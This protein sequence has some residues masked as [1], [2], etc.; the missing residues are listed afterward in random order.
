MSSQKGKTHN[1]PSSRKPYE[2]SRSG[3][4]GRPSTKK[5][6][7]APKKETYFDL[8]RKKQ[9]GESGQSPV[10]NNI[11]SE[12][13]ISV[14]L[15][16]ASQKN[17]SDRMS[18]CC[19]SNNKASVNVDNQGTSRNHCTA[20]TSTN[21]LIEESPNDFM[22]LETAANEEEL[23]FNID[24]KFNS[25]DD[26]EVT[27]KGLIYAIN[28]SLNTLERRVDDKEL[29]FEDEMQDNE[30]EQELDEDEQELDEDELELDE[31]EKELDEDEQELDED[32]KE[33]D[34]DELELDEDEQDLDE[35]KE[36]L[37]EVDQELDEENEQELDE[38]DQELDEENE[39]ELDEDEQELD[40]DKQELDEDERDLDEDEQEL[41]EDEK[42]LDDEVEQ[43][44]QNILEVV[45]K[46]KKEAVKGLKKSHEESQPTYK[47]ASFIQMQQDFSWL[48][49]DGVN[50]G[51]K[52]KMC[53][54][55]PEGVAF[56][57]G[58]NKFKFSHEA[59]KDLSGHPMRK[60]KVHEDSKKHKYALRQYENFRTRQSLETLENNKEAKDVREAKL[61]KIAVEKL[62][63]ITVYMV[64]KNW[65]HVQNYN[66]FV[67]FIGRDL[68]ESV[69]SEYLKMASSH[70]NAT[71]LSNFTVRKFVKLIGEYIEKKT[72]EK[73]K[74]CKNFTI[75]LDESTDDANRS[76]LALIARI[77]DEKGV[78]QNHFL[79]LIQLQRCDALSIFTAVYDYLKKNEID[80][81]RICFSG[82]DGCSTMMGEHKGVAQHFKNHCSHHSSIHC[83]NHRLALC[84]SHLIPWY[85]PFKN[86][87]GLLLNLFLMLKHSSVKT[88]LFNEIQQ[89][90]DL[91]SLK[92]IKAATTRWLSHG[93]ASQRVLDRFEPLITTLIAIYE[94][95]K[96]PAVQGL[97]D[98][99]TEPETIA[100]LCFLSDVMQCTNSFQV[101]LQ[102]SRLNFLD[103][104]G[105]AKELTDKL[106]LIK[107]NPCRPNSNFE[108]LDVFL[109]VASK[110]ERLIN[111][112][113][114]SVSRSS[115]SKEKYTNDVIKPFISDLIQEIEQS[116]EIPSHLK[117]FSV[118]D[119]R[120][121]PNN[122][123]ELK[124]Y[125][126]DSIVLL[127]NFYGV[128]SNI[129]TGHFHSKIINHES[130]QIQFKVFKNFAFV[131]KFEYE[132][133]QRKNLE[134][135]L[136]EK[137]NLENKL[138]SL[139][140]LL[141]SRKQ[142]II[143]QQIKT[144]DKKIA[145]LR[146]TQKMSFEIMLKRWYEKNFQEKHHDISKMLEFAALIPPST[147]EV[148]RAFSLMKLIC[149]RLRRSL[150]QV[151][152]AHCMRI[153]K[154]ELTKDDFLQI[155]D[156]W[157]GAEDT[158]SKKRKISSRL[159]KNMK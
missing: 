50:N 19:F 157:L 64:K 128:S 159:S 144:L 23:L 18:E 30:D 2:R 84:F 83:R 10:T 13:N 4:G 43:D 129:G 14:S 3:I 8:L 32:E 40:E 42:E 46:D 140:D 72:I 5:N 20:S 86:F 38:V 127:S 96:E 98:E 66:D 117:G 109:E 101:F 36:D 48:Y 52:C 121:L 146:K 56:S 12:E 1:Y 147:S 103:L 123:E 7:S 45:E 97:L 112:R 81:T 107:T 77:V 102:H 68:E 69:L 125:G 67:T 24:D 87:D 145:E 116:F 114:R 53:E 138:M 9:S 73:I 132:N 22:N 65:A 60:L 115:F 49:Y 149:T 76:E 17:Q 71:Y 106:D 74:K 63:R 142:T 16:S 55:F 82:M 124:D 57:N 133:K 75:L 136:R 143:K 79:T 27:K 21:S 25:K 85:K 93:K 15:L 91:E 59:V 156:K 92:L 80:I 151:N 155:I 11:E 90:Y 34:E 122:R 118:L 105:K 28:T 26:F 78:V 104:P 89:S 137:T 153:S 94:R 154:Y 99:L 130:L 152:L 134:D 126:N 141:T 111:T 110:Q 58:K 95:K 113:S 139:S 131:E 62:L 6:I 70:K 158:K 108:K 41:D 54:L 88:S 35:D 120:N 33:L 31:D 44:K 29:L 37:D 119:P 39:Q 47:R 61:T 135:S 148:E 100:T 150:A 51:Y